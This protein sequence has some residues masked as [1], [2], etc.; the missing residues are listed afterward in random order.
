MSMAAAGAEAVVGSSG[1]Q[2]AMV[3]GGNRQ[4]PGMGVSLACQAGL[5]SS[6][7]CF[8]RENFPKVLRLSKTATLRQVLVNLLHHFIPHG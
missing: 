7:E 4:L 1:L 6:N 5:R 3:G 8:R 2:W